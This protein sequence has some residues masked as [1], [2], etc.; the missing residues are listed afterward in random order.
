M[1]KVTLDLFA[2]LNDAKAEAVLT[3]PYKE[4]VK[5]INAIMWYLLPNVLKLFGKYSPFILPKR[6]KTM[7]AKLSPPNI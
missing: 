1:P 3:R 5:Q 2:V 7:A 6:Q 4:T